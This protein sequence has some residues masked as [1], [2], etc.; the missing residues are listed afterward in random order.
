MGLEI[1]KKGLSGSALNAVECSITAADKD[2]N[3]ISQEEVSVF[4]TE[5]KKYKDAGW[6]SKK[7]YKQVIDSLEITDE[8]AKAKEAPTVTITTKKEKRQADRE[9]KT[10]AKRNENTTLRALG[11]VAVAGTEREDLISKLNDKLGT[12]SEQENFIELKETIKKVIEESKNLDYKDLK[13]INKNERDLRKA[14]K[15]EKI[16]DKVLNQIIDAVNASIKTELV[17]EAYG[18]VIEIYNVLKEG[19]NKNPDKHTLDSLTKGVINTMIA[20]GL[21]TKEDVTVD[22]NGN[23]KL[24][25]GT[26]YAEAM[27][28][29]EAK[30][31]RPAAGEIWLDTLVDQDIETKKGKVKRDTIQQLKDAG[32]YDSRVKD[33]ANSKFGDDISGRAKVKT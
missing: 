6:L 28:L 5:L 24:A 15:S 29:Y 33:Y 18:K 22:A 20:Q 23:Y 19:K 9:A 27:K 13:D 21:I 16:D 2:K 14:L 3:G 4:A 8:T 26:A 31:M 7:E 10:D 17:T 32:Q 1:N 11:E 25:E 12:N 30:V